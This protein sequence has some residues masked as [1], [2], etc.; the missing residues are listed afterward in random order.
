VFMTLDPKLGNPEWDRLFGWRELAQEVQK[1]REGSPI[2]TTDYEYASE[3]S[4]YLQDH[5]SIWPLTDDLLG[6]HRPT[7]FDQI[8]GYAAPSVYPRVLLVR[9]K[10]DYGDKGDDLLRDDEH[11]TQL[12]TNEWGYVYCGR[13]IRTSL[14]TVATK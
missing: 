2:Y 10:H 9:M 6:V 4:F 11:F 3:L 1:Y 8:P 7:V 5:P 14:I 13:T 12:Q